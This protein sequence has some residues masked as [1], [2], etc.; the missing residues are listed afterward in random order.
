LTWFQILGEGK[1]LHPNISPE[2]TT[3]RLAEY[4]QAGKKKDTFTPGS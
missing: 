1:V 2:K 4:A 3:S